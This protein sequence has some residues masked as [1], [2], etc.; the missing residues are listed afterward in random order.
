MRTGTWGGAHSG[1]GHIAGKFGRRG[2]HEPGHMTGAHG[3]GHMGR[4]ASKI[5]ENL[6]KSRTIYEHLRTSTKI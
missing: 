1:E 4:G 6:R 3:E 2:A 5:N